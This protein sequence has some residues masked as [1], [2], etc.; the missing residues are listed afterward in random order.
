MV[1]LPT[2]TIY[3]LP[4]G[5][6]YPTDGLEPSSATHLSVP[7]VHPNAEISRNRRQIPGEE[8]NQIIRA[9]Q[10]MSGIESKVTNMSI[11]A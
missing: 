6:T 11:R 10:D 4:L 7:Q 2:A 1:T 8:L 3:L 9:P 5:L